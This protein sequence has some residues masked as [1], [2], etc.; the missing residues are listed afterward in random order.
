MLFLVASIDKLKLTKQK[1]MK[2]LI[3]SA[4]GVC[5]LFS[6]ITSFAQSRTG[7]WCY[8]DEQTQILEQLDPNIIQQRADMEDMIKNYESTY[9]PVAKKVTI[10]IPI[11]FHVITWQGVGNALKSDIENAVI[12]LNRDFTRTNPDASSTRALFVP[13][14]ASL[15]I[16]FRLARKD[17]NGNCTEGIVRIEDSRTTNATDAIKS[18]SYWDSKKYFNVWV[19]DLINGS[20]PPS[21]VAGY[22][23]FPSSGINSTYGVVIDNSFLNGR[24]LTHEIGHCF[25]LYHT[26]QSGCGSNSCSSSGDMCC[27]TPPVSTSSGSCDYS[28]NTCSNDVNHA[29]YNSN[30]LDQIENYMSYNACQNMFSLDQKTRMMATLNSGSPTTGLAQIWTPGNLAF[31]GTADPYDNNPICIPWGADF[32]F[33]K[34]KICE[35][36]SVT[37]S[38][39]QTYNATPTLWNWT[40]AGGT[41][42]SSTV[43]NPVITYNT[44]GSYGATYSPGTTAG[45]YTPAVSK[46]NIITV[47]SIAAQYQLPFSEG[48]ENV[49]TFNTDWS[50]VTSSGSGWTNSTTAAY[51]GTRALRVNNIT[52]S[53]NDITEAISSSID[54][55]SMSSPVLTWRSAYAKKTS[56]G[57][58]ILTIYSSIDCGASWQIMTVKTASTMSSAPATNS[59]FTPLGTSQWKDFSFTITPTLAAKSNVRL[60]FHFKSNGGNNM[61]LD[62]INI[63][64]IIG[65]NENKLVN[66]LSIYPNPM[67]ESAVL[68]FNLID[69]VK[70]LSIS[71]KDVLGKEVTKII[72]GQSFAA[73]KYTLS[74]DQQKK[75]QSGLYFIEFNADN[76][77]TIEKL[78]VR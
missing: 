3:L 46:S 65:V 40:F 18:A 75:L 13:Y 49:T 73:G 27:D 62:D 6:S 44:Q 24:T 47:S 31:T 21:Y 22:A 60:K 43:S 36:D 14:A 9:D 71:M 8:T 16:Q 52:N 20:N 4:I 48:M 1:N 33:N 56:G 25:G 41:P 39:Y 51:T 12:T 55:A 57:N 70:N 69:G 50:I 11:V 17:P 64:G 68:S 23:Q 30:V 53:V 37:F 28:E 34:T 15:D 5:M 63:T 26:F 45:Y 58:D 78:I 35:G 19:V 38:D 77:I 67:N 29:P 74:I 61:Y 7:N 2:K 32:V 76:K 59:S 10:I 72:N 54:F 66:N 42:S